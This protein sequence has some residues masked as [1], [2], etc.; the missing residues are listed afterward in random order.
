V[1]GVSILAWL[2]LD[3]RTP[4]LA[5]QVYRLSE[6][7]RF[8]LAV[9]DNNWYAGHHVPGYSLLLGPLGSLLGLQAMGAIAVIVSTLCFGVLMREHF[10]GRASMATAFFAAAATGDL[11]IGRIT[12]ALGVTLGLAAVVALARRQWLLA[13]TFAALCAAASPVSGLFL[14][15]AGVALALGLK[16]AGPGVVVAAPALVLVVAMSLLFP[17]GGREPFPFSSFAATLAAALAFVVLTARGQRVLRVAGAIYVI[18]VVLAVLISSPMGANVARLAVLFAWPLL[19]AS[20][21]AG[22]FAGVSRGGLVLVLAGIALVGWTV[23]GPVRE[24]A[25]VSGDLAVRASFYRPV[26]AFLDTHLT[27]PMRIEVPF[28]R[29]HW[30]TTY[31]GERFALARGWE[32]QLDTRYDGLF[33]DGTL[34]DAEYLSWLRKLAVGYVLL[35]DVVLDGSS[36]AEARLIRS[37]PPFLRLVFARGGWRVYRVTDSLAIAQGPGRMLAL[38]GD[39][40]TLRATRAGRFLV[41]V[42]YTRYWAVTAGAGCVGRAGGGWTSVVALRAGL[43]RV[44]ANFSVARALGF[45]GGGGSGCDAGRARG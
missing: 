41:R 33:F 4:D 43:V 12:F 27:A 35:P 11:W 21:P 5:A 40:F 16:R 7:R 17:E 37:Q 34:T 10:A 44:N 20:A 38:T 32:R 13:A 26:E 39:G 3:P 42:H 24:V 30:E 14:A 15:L 23:W 25:K 36:V 2:A 31:L 29:S 6:Y 19:F 28:T 22:T 9:W 8:G 18:A 1:A 45:V